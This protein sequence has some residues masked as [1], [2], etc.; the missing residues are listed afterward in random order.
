MKKSL[1]DGDLLG[2]YRTFV[3][4]GLI[5]KKS[6]E[7]II[8]KKA[9]KDKHWFLELIPEEGEISENREIKFEI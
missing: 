2:E 9:L 8:G 1:G 4:D 5:F 7:F 3:Y 6:V